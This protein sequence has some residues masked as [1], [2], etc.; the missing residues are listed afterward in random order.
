MNTSIQLIK[1]I[2]T[3]QEHKQGHQITAIQFEDGSGLKVNYQLD[4][5]KWQYIDLRGFK[6]MAATEP[7]ENQTD[8]AEN[9]RSE[10]LGNRIISFLNLKVKGDKVETSWG[11]KTALGL[12]ASILRIIDEL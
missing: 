4:G 6:G 11:T 3:L 8:E 1:A 5:G 10:T 9:K 12:G 2:Q 7:T